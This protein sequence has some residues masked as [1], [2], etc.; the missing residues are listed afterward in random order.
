MVREVS[1]YLPDVP[2]QFSRVLKALKDA[3]VNIRGFSVDLAGAVSLLRLLF[4]N[5]TEAERASKALKEHAYETVERDLLLV[6]RPDEPG[7]LLKVTDLIAENDINVEYGYVALGQ[8][9]TGEVI[10]ALKVDNGKANLA[11]ACLEAA[12]IK[13]HDEIPDRS[14]TSG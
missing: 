12:G 13:N 4:K 2:G 11:I 14:G 1:V 8:T 6:S 10:F 3:N 5:S 9:E 7:E